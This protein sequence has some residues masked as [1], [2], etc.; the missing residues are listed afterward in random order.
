MKILVI[1]SG[2]REHALVWKISQSK[3]VEKIFCAPGNAGIAQLAECVTIAAD[4]IS[5]L[6]DFAKNKAIDVTVVGPEAPLVAGIVDV[7]QK[8]GLKVFGP[9][10]Q[11]ARL[12]ASK[13]FAKEIM[14]KYGVPTA[15]FEVCRSV[16]EVEKALKRLNGPVVVK[17]D[18]L[19]AGKGVILCEGSI[20]ALEAAKSMLVDKIFGRAGETVVIEECLYG[21]E[22]SILALTNGGQALALASSQ[23]HKRVSDG[24]KGPNTGGMGAYS[25]APIVT[26]EVMECIM[27]TV[28]MPVLRGLKSEGLEYRGILYAGIMLTEAGPKV[29]EFNVRFGDPETQAVLVRLESDILDAILW[30]LEPDNPAPELKW[31]KKASVCVVMASGGYPGPYEKSKKIEGLEKAGKLKDVVVFHAGT[32]LSGKDYVTCGGRVLG[33]TGLGENIN[34]AIDNVYKAVGLIHFDGAHF[35]RDIG[36]R[37]KEE[38]EML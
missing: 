13:S 29:L 16:S 2:A 19:A 12:E 6:L 26:D 33:V 5:S 11:A 38:K 18:G 28:V 31:T 21:Q 7:F 23:D 37:A 20:A 8:A 9:R 15:D 22:A 3:Q 36:W 25:P 30:T 17:A 32:E 14:K 27:K 34:A 1:G 4:N 10:K 35:R 24:D